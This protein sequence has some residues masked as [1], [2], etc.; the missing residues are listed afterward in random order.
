M[1]DQSGHG[2][3]GWDFNF[4]GEFYLD[5]TACPTDPFAFIDLDNLFTSE[6]GVDSNTPFL[7]GPISSGMDLFLGNDMWMGSLPTA[8]HNNF[9]EINIS[10]DLDMTLSY[11]AGHK[12]N[13]HTNSSS[14]GMVT[15]LTSPGS[16]L[17]P[18]QATYQ[19]V[20]P[21]P[22]KPKKRRIEEFQSEFM[23]PQPVVSDKPRRRPYRDERRKEVGMVRQVGACIR[24]RLMKTPVSRIRLPDY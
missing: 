1:A 2:P 4:P 5:P 7:H 14:S 18:G 15:P 23:G 24:C 17:F 9:D 8:P 16:S 13:S 19:P 10:N 20:P 12:S 11:Q 3:Q 22:K 6:L 21:L